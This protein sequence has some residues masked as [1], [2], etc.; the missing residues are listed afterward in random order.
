MQNKVQEVGYV[1]KQTKKLNSYFWCHNGVVMS[2]ND[3]ISAHDQGN[4]VR[5]LLLS[6]YCMKSKT[7][8]SFATTGRFFIA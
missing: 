2:N 3:G 4:K 7:V 1:I 5:K 6:G 8:A